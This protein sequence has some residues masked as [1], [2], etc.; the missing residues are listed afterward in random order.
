MVGSAVLSMGYLIGLFL[1]GSTSGLTTLFLYITLA[2]SWNLIGGFAGY[3]SFGQVAFVGVGGYSVGAL[4]ITLGMPFWPALFLGGL[5]AALFAGILGLILLRIRGP[6]FSIATLVAAEATSGI[7]EWWVGAV[8]SGNALTITTVGLREPTRYLGPYGFMLAFG[9][10][11]LFSVAIV[12]LVARS[13]F[14]DSLVL[15]REREMLTA[16]LGVDARRTKVA[17]FAL[18]ALLAGF[19]GGI[20]AFREVILDPTKL[21]DPSLTILTVAIVVVGGAGTVFGPLYGAVI[22]TALSNLINSVDPASH[23]L[24]IA[25]SI[26][27]GVLASRSWLASRESQDGGNIGIRNWKTGKIGMR[28]V[29]AVG[30]DQ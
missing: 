18:S 3:A 1:N 13:R 16:A 19:A 12:A 23:D 6:Y 30:K 25:I 26:V 27:G 14:G 20:M 10:L 15:I 7:V 5:A 28:S 8:R 17:V 2:Q 24:I 29:V 21:F 22:I 11:A 9:I 4:M